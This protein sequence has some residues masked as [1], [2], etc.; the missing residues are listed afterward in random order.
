MA[1]LT[2]PKPVRPLH[3]EHIHVEKKKT[4]WLWL[5]LPL[6]LLGLLAVL[7]MNNRTEPTADT[8]KGAAI[9]GDAVV[10]DKVVGDTRVITYKNKKWEVKGGSETFPAGEVKLVNRSDEGDA[11]YVHQGKGYLE[12]KGA[13]PVKNTISMPSGRV[14]LKNPDGSYQPLFEKP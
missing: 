14:Y 1:N 7:F 9:V 13:D 12:G 5:L 3:A 2:E 10:G 6:F 8:T 11:L 4:P